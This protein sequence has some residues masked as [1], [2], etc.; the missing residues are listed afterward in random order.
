ME[1][2]L[3]RLFEFRANEGGDDEDGGEDI[4]EDVEDDVDTDEND[5]VNAD[6]GC[7]ELAL[8][9]TELIR[10]FLLHS[11]SFSFCF[12]EVLH[13]T[14][15]K[16]LSL[17]IDESPEDRCLGQFSDLWLGLFVDNAES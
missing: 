5:G 3:L 1:A 9:L 2:A 15:W 10:I 11:S 12:V 7:P 17:L 13:S 4:D 14:S 16:T 8:F 6:K